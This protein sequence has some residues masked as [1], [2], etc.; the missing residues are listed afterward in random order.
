MQC[1]FSG[2]PDAKTIK[3]HFGKPSSK[4]VYLYLKSDTQGKLTVITLQHNAFSHCDFLLLQKDQ[5]ELDFWHLSIYIIKY[6]PKN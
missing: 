6:S 2:V 1:V 3:E 4:R 5:F